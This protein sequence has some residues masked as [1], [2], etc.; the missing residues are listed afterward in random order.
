MMTN[1][2][3][4][5]T[6]FTLNPDKIKKHMVNKLIWTIKNRIVYVVNHSLPHSS[7]GYAVRTHTVAK[8]MVQNGCEVVVITRPGY[9]FDLDNAAF[10][11]VG[12]C[13]LIDDVRYVHLRSPRKVGENHQL[14][15]QKSEQAYKTF[16][17][18]CKP[19]AVVAASNWELALPAQKAAKELGLPFCYEVRGF[20]EISRG[21]VDQQFMGSEEFSYLVK[22]ETAA[23][24]NADKI[25]TLNRFM[26]QELIKRGVE[27]H[28]IDIIPNG[29]EASAI[30]TNVKTKAVDR[31]FTIGYIGSFARY[32]GL[33]ILLEVIDVLKTR[34]DEVNL[35]LVGSSNTLGIKNA[36]CEVSQE[37]REQAKKLGIENN[38]ELTGR[39]PPKEAEKYYDEIDLIVIPRKK[40]AVSELV[41]PI[42][43]L[44]AA[45]RGKAMLLSDIKPFEEFF[46]IGIA[47]KIESLSAKTIADQVLEFIRS[48]KRLGVLGEKAQQWSLRERQPSHIT[49]KLAEF[50]KQLPSGFE[51]YKDRLK[52]SEA[53]GH[54]EEE[55]KQKLETC[56]AKFDFV[57]IKKSEKSVIVECEAEQILRLSGALLTEDNEKK[58]AALVQVELKGQVPSKKL[59]NMIG[60]SFSEKLG[61]F[62]YLPTHKTG[63]C[64]WS[65]QVVVPPSCN[66]AKF[67][68][69]TWFS[70]HKILLCLS[71]VR[72]LLSFE[73]YVSDAFNRYGNN[74]STEVLEDIENKYRSELIAKNLRKVFDLGHISIANDLLL[75]VK[76]EHKITY[77][78]HVNTVLGYMNVAKR[79][80]NVPSRI[81]RKLET[82]NA[83]CMVAHTSLPFHSNGYATRTHEIAKQLS[84]QHDLT[85]LTRPGYP[86]DV[87]NT[88]VDSEEKNLIDG[89]LY[90]NI[91]G[92][93]YYEDSLTDYI[94]NATR[95]LLKEFI[96]IK[97][98][99]VHAASSIHNALPSLI[100]ARTLGIPFIYEVRGFWEVTRA[101]VN[102][103]WGE[104]ERYKIEH[105]LEI[106][107]A[108]Q[109]DHVVALTGGIKEELV[110]NGLD[111]KTITIV[112]N[113][114]SI[115]KFTH[116]S[117]SD[118]KYANSKNNEPVIGYVGA[119]VEYEGLD[120][121]IDALEIV[122]KKGHQFKL[123]IA[124]DGNRL[125]AITQQ[126]KASPISNCI[127]L[128]GR[129]P[130]EEVGALIDAI[131]IMPLPRKPLPVCEMV[132]PLK[133]FESMICKKALVGSDVAAIAEIIQH[134][135]TGLLFQKG[136]IEDLA[137]KIIQLIQSPVYRKTL[138][139]NAYK[140][141]TENKT[142]EKVS[143]SY[144]S[145]YREAE[146]AFNEKV[147]DAETPTKILV[148]GDVD[149]NYIDGS[150]V[151]AA[152]ITDVLSSLPNTNVDILLKAD[153]YKSKVI[154]QISGKNKSVR[155]ISPTKFGRAK[156]L[157][158]SDAVPLIQ[159]LHQDQDYDVILIRG[160]NIYSELAKSPELDGVLW[161]YPIE[162]LQKADADIEK[163][164]LIPLKR[165]SKLLCQS[166]AFKD[167]LIELGYDE[168]KIVFVPPMVP[169]KAKTNR[170]LASN[171]TKKKL[172]Y[173]GK[174]DRQWGV[175]EMFET[176]RSLYH[177]DQQFELHVYGE[178]I[179][180]PKRCEL[181]ESQIKDYL[182]MPGVVWHKGVERELVL[183]ELPSYDLAWA[184]RQPELD[185]DTKEIST[186]FLEYSSSTLPIICLNGSMNRTLLGDDYP[187][188]VE[189]QSQLVEKIKHF[190]KTPSM[191]NEA[192]DICSAAVQPF[193]FSSVAQNNLKPALNDVRPSRKQ[194]VLVAGHDLKF[195]NS[196]MR[197][198]RNKGFRVLTDKWQGHQ[199]HNE[200]QSYSK[201]AS[202]DVVICEWALGNSV[203]YTKRKLNQ[204]KLMVRLHLQEESTD[205]PLDI[206]VDKID[207]FNFI[208]HQVQRKVNSK[209]FNNKNVGEFF[210]NYIHFDEFSLPKATDSQF[211][212]G[213]IGIVPQRKRFDLALD[214]LEQL[215]KLDKRFTLRVKGKLPKDFPWMINRK[216][217]MQYYEDQYKRIEQSELL[218]GAVIFD[219]HGNDMDKW[220]T[221]I[222]YILST[223]D[224]EGSHQAVAEGMASG[225]VPLILPWEGADELYPEKYVFKT[226]DSMVD[227]VINQTITEPEILEIKAHV[228][229]WDLKILN[230]LLAERLGLH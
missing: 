189:D 104:S 148:Y 33:E 203:W 54:V 25:F 52:Q 225:C 173:A 165:A 129:I 59:A 95:V 72:C 90:K 163:A 224:F 20:W 69:K 47:A 187:L 169:D 36:M 176:F 35:L 216:D 43:P 143:E 147:K 97:P 212:L 207:F 84:K 178:K 141:V 46:D 158:G 144:H 65:I 151:W 154:K 138:G 30:S 91:T 197:E 124:G 41:S 61:F 136:N 94:E 183:R 12:N 40:L 9:P 21:S 125:D 111:E 115:D 32:E 137:D 57:D 96:D 217:E 99:L 55:R 17:K 42:K 88:V 8:G 118:S 60:V 19:T 76:P 156:R 120:D 100:A 188:F 49:L 10:D 27:A 89:V 29:F 205:Y 181:F 73:R 229:S 107:I 149:L 145:I 153:A 86:H 24:K 211:T 218:S 34:G 215:H 87:I 208:N 168:Q 170:I 196:H 222:G 67:T 5:P 103:G 14:W 135:K 227:K 122:A 191:L 116:V 26:K 195:I 81:S 85:V 228:K 202:A 155:I 186:K 109:A 133:P 192:A 3:W 221:K 128:L 92:A 213:F 172:V 194:T 167:R 108:S 175:I 23:A 182:A 119:I 98:K 58:N 102:P 174:F 28:K 179:H 177:E 139:E 226:I 6:I 75:Y 190:F 130:H 2:P 45:A 112:S 70:T 7:N 204:Q 184:W 123:V 82:T 101:S 219:G 4:A 146:L 37:L 13:N 11:D 209:F 114:I 93:H 157:M 159:Q 200:L 71:E 62:C 134:E 214:L 162:L 142:W 117:L 161:I 79:L 193:F 74:F 220:F 39:V 199:G 64:D 223:S 132:S 140:W 121:L 51:A 113:A 126:V 201:L 48:P 16:F 210:P 66:E 180:N 131:D 78:R 18:V 63:H 160:Q 50:I 166:L 31:R 38:V 105:D 150:S 1:K 56:E 22:Q 152:S 68:F 206:D 106:F 127:D 15:L 171:S 44:E 230:H 53:A 110:N 164:D 198:F 80:P 185:K 83:V 77:K